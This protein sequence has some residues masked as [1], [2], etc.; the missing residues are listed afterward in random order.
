M[1]TNIYN[2]KTQLMNVKEEGVLKIIPDNMINWVKKY[3]YFSNNNSIEF[4]N[5]FTL[6]LEKD[7][8]ILKHWLCDVSKIE[9]G[10]QKIGGNMF[11]LSK[12]KKELNQLETMFT[13]KI[14]LFNNYCTEDGTDYMNMQFKECD[15]D[16]ELIDSI[17]DKWVL[18]NSNYCQLL[19]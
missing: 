9:E 8:V 3:M 2:N 12:F 6:Y 11:I 7:I 4:I 5:G 17:I 15:F 1:N 10:L 14:R 13:D 19:L 18:I 16:S